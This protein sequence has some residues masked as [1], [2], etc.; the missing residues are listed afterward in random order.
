MAVLGRVR[1]HLYD[2]C[3]L[4]LG[5]SLS[6]VYSLSVL[7][8][9]YRVLTFIIQQAFLPETRGLPLEEVDDYFARVPLFIPHSTVPVPTQREREDALRQRGQELEKGGTSQGSGSYDDEKTA[10][11]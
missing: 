3:A 6:L 1:R 7:F 8:T 11:A 5:G 10:E 4:P 2:E 9:L